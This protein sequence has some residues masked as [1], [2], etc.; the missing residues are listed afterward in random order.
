MGV[1]S[2]RKRTDK[3]FGSGRCACRTQLKCCREIPNRLAARPTPFRL[4]ARFD[5]SL[6]VFTVALHILHVTV[7]PVNAFLLSYG[8]VWFDLLHMP[9]THPMEP[10]EREICQRLREFRARTGL[11]RVAFGKQVN[12]DTTTLSNIEHAKCRVRFYVAHRVAEAFGLSYR[13]LAE[14]EQPVWDHEPLHDGAVRDATSNSAPFSEVYDQRLKD[15]LAR[16]SRMKTAAGRAGV[17]LKY[18]SPVGAPRW[19]LRLRAV[20]SDLETTVA[21]VPPNLFAEFRTMLV[22]TAQEFLEQRGVSQEVKGKPG[23]N[24]KPDRGGAGPKPE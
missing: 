1:E 2:A 7:Q 22:T 8:A 15:E 9:R 10:R 13:W 3:L 6:S 19:D 17:Y 16:R 18:R 14:N 11:S 12:L 4:A 23:G 24:V 21:A 5:L 20:M